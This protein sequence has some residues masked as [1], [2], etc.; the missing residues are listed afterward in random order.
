MPVDVK[1]NGIGGVAADSAPVL[2]SSTPV[3]ARGKHPPSSPH[4]PRVQGVKGS[5][6][7]V[8]PVR[9]PFE[10]SQDSGRFLPLNPR[11]LGS[12]N[13]LF[14]FTNHDPSY[15]RNTPNLCSGIGAF[16]DMEIPRPRAILV[17]KGSRMPSSHRR[18]VLK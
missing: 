1:E 9:L 12:L 7:Q 8:N 18:A 4:H 16:N 17:S 15:I 11:I 13:P 3:E 5:R 14:L 2:R 10:Y 6:I